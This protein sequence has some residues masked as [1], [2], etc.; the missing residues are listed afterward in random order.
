MIHVTGVKDR[1]L[2]AYILNPF[3]LYLTD[4][5]VDGGAFI[6][7]PGVHR[8]IGQ[9]MQTLPQDMNPLRPNKQ[10]QLFLDFEQ[11]LE[12]LPADAE[13]IKRE[14]MSLGTKPIP[15]Q[16]GDLIIWHSGLPHGADRN[17]A[18]HPRVAQYMKCFQPKKRMRR[19]EIIA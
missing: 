18:E 6:C 2:S 7:V 3:E 19:P 9:W 1:S 11:W 10:S 8:K 15:A 14:L 16:A 4:T 13:D 17:R 5:T 12:A